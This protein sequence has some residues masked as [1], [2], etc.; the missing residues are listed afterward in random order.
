VR[1]PYALASRGRL[2]PNLAPAREAAETART[3][4]ADPFAASVLPAIADIQATGA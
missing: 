4:N 1:V 3:K 2:D